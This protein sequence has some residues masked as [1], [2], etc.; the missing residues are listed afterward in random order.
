MLCAS[1]LRNQGDK[2]EFCESILGQEVYSISIAYF[3]SL[4]NL[5]D[6]ASR[7][8]LEIDPCG[9]PIT[10]FPE[11][12]SLCNQ[13]CIFPRLYV[14]ECMFIVRDRRNRKREKEREGIK[15]TEEI[16]E[17]QDEEIKIQKKGKEGMYFDT[18]YWCKIDISLSNTK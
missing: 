4:Q 12:S 3:S 15:N 1:R 13:G 11:K 10:S 18:I 2:R 7:F 14:C 5:A 16:R 8:R 6:F 17:E 9:P